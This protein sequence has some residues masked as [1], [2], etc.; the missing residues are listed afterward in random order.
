MTEQ[1]HTGLK[2]DD[3]FEKFYTKPDTVTLCLQEF[4]KYVHP[5]PHDI[6]IEPTAGN[7]AFYLPLKDQYPT[8]GMDIQPEHPEIMPRDFFTFLY[9]KP[10]DQ[11]MRVHVIGNPPFGRQAT[12][13]RKCIQH[14]ATFA[15]T[16]S[17]I[18]P[19]SFKK[20]S[21]MQ[22]FPRSFHCLFSVDLPTNSFLLYGENHDVPCVFQIWE[23]RTE[24]R[25]ELT[26]ITPPA[27]Y[28]KYV[29][30]ME[31]PT[32]AVRRVGV[33]AGQLYTD[34]ADKSEQSHYFLKV[35]VPLTEFVTQYQ[36]QVHFHHGNTVGPRSVSKYELNE[37][38]MTLYQ[39]VPDWWSVD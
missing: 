20:P 5:Q 8:I 33:Y 28:Y 21:M 35:Y 16:I 27:H 4:Q 34:T 22:S 11:E 14:A 31:Q 9:Q 18:L 38:L 32:V 37:A 26:L 15:D 1:F 12:M 17:F 23:K 36:N 13:A 25:S 6:C 29:K 10:A 30:K 39:T 2:R 3:T 24:L 7:G 19:R